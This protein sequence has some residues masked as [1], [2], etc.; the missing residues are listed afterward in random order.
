M[1]RGCPS[2][3]GPVRGGWRG[4]SGWR[5]PRRLFGR[6]F[7]CRFGDGEVLAGVDHIMVDAEADAFPDQRG[8]LDDLGAGTEEEADT[9]MRPFIGSKDI[10][11][12][13]PET[14]LAMR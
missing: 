5:L 13:R 6:L 1:L 10:I 14:G 7:V 3:S 4:G 8:H 2:L 9:H 11:L 12:G